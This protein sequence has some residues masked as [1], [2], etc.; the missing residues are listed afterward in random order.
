MKNKLSIMA[1]LLAAAFTT[2]PFTAQP[3]CVLTVES[4]AYV[5]DISGSMME[6]L[7][8]RA[9]EEPERKAQKILLVREAVQQINTLAQKRGPL[10]ASLF[11]VAPYTNQ[12]P[13]AE[14]SAEDFGRGLEKLNPKLEVFGRPTWVGERAQARFNE[15][16][17]RPQT[18]ILF[19]DGGFSKERRDPVEVL[20]DFYAANPQSCIHF[21]SLA[22]TDEQRAG[23]ESLASLKACS[24]TVAVEDLLAQRAALERFVAE[25][26]PIE[27]KEPE[28]APAVTFKGVNFDFDKATLTPE[29]K[30]LLNRA[31]EVIRGRPSGERIRIV[32]WTDWFGSDAYNAGLSKRRAAAVKA[33]LVLHGV[34]AARIEETGSGKSFRYTNETKHGRWLNRRVDLILGDSALV[35]EDAR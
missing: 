17:G 21:V 10:P 35:S 32:G 5:V 13:L 24:K 25:V 16:V 30:E 6:K 20:K 28:K 14:R 26:F 29:A 1:A 11:T 8:V 3:D 22:Q 31:L 9:G 15:A 33:Y 23:V 12:M 2:A 27:C 18:V 19:T 7:S 34:D 4:A